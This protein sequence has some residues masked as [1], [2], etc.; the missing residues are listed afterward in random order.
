MQTATL[1]ISQPNRAPIKLEADGSPTSIGRAAGNMVCLDGDDNVSSYHAVIEARGDGW[2]V[3]DLGSRNGTTVNGEQVESE[4]RLS[5]GDVICVGGGSTIEIHPRDTGDGGDSPPPPNWS[6][7]MTVVAVVGGL[8]VTLVVLVLLGR[9]I[10]SRTGGEEAARKNNNQQTN[11]QPT[12]PPTPPPAT[13]APP[14]IDSVTLPPPPPPPPVSKD[15]D[16]LRELARTLALQISQKNVYTFDPAFVELI[17]S[18]IDEYRADPR[19]FERARRYSDEINTEFTNQNVPPLLGYIM[20][21]SVSKFEDQ[22]G[23]IWQLPPSV[24][25]PAPQDGA[26]G[27]SATAGSTRAAAK[28]I[29]GLLNQFEVQGFP[30]VAACY[31]MT[32][33]EYGEVKNQLERKD[34]DGQNRYDFWKMKN[35]N[36]VRDQQVKRVARFFA[37]GIVCE[38][39]EQYGLKTKSLSTLVD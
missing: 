1:I 27:A 11:T 38:N 36:V 5:D 13:P 16:Q 26:P 12:R 8:A 17:R 25:E 15:A 35:A 10:S 19:Y 37:A 20:A 34:P 6:K 14:G 9:A 3:C 24:R 21:M 22:G 18:Y 23:G 31:G 39:P 29:R 28:Y 4:R 33:S 32:P 2:W 30:Y 7:V